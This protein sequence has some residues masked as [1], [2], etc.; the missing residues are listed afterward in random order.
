MN[1]SV[2]YNLKS[3]EVKVAVKTDLLEVYGWESWH[4]DQWTACLQPGNWAGAEED[5]VPAPGLAGF[6]DWPGTTKGW[7]WGALCGL[8]LARFCCGSNIPNTVEMA[9]PA[10]SQGRGRR[11]GRSGRRPCGC[12]VTVMVPPPSR[13]IPLN[14][15]DSCT[16]V[17]ALKPLWSLAMGKSLWN[18]TETLSLIK[19]LIYSFIQ[20]PVSQALSDSRH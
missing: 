19:K 12:P 10:S 9:S 14:P 1:S 8:F 5:S 4:L 2:D 3:G 17:P 6:P 13:L 20:Q 11:T 18:W 7:Q 16:S 15:V